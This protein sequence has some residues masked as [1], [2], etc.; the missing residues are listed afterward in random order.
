VTSIH[1]VL[2]RRSYSSIRPASLVWSSCLKLLVTVIFVISGIVFVC[3]GGP[4]GS[5]YDSYVGGRYYSDPGA[6]GNGF[7]GVCSVFVTAAF[8][9]AGTELVGLAASETPNPRKTMPSA[10]KNTF[11]RITLIYITSLTLIG[12]LIPYNDERLLSGTSSYDAA[13]SPFV[14]AFNYAN[15][16]GLDHLVNATICI[17]VLSIGLSCVYAGSRTLTA[18]AET[19]YAP[20]FFTYVDKS[21]R[22]LWSVIAILAFGPI[23]YV[24][25]ASVGG[26]VFNWLLALSGLSTIFTWMSICLCHIRFRRAWKVQGHSVEELPFRAAGGVYGSWFGFGLLALVLAAQFYVAVWPIGFKELSVN[27]RVI[28]FFREY[29]MHIDPF[30]F[31]RMT[32]RLFRL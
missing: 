24:N 26:Q 27:E 9:F 18:L 15:V 30:S 28:G 16:K 4:S 19:G 3:G 23:A 25:V 7:K 13:A 22:P 32:D 31:N 11:W 6:F 29:R 1:K 10:V 5:R 2:I 21:G 17:S 20:R 14:L 12:L 8:S